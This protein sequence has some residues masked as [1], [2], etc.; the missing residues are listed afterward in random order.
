MCSGKM[1]WSRKGDFVRASDIDL[2]VCGGNTA[3]FALDVDEETSTPLK[4]D[5]VNL[6]EDVQDELLQVIAREGKVL[7]EKIWE[8]CFKSTCV[9]AGG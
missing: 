8:F 9:G 6:D 4:Y 1:E 7:Y 5:V 2:A 3:R